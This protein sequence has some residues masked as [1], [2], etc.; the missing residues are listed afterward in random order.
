MLL[1]NIYIIRK[2]STRQNNDIDGFIQAPFLD[3]KLDKFFLEAR[4][5]RAHQKQQNHRHGADEPQGGFVHFARQKAQRSEQTERN[6]YDPSHV[7]FGQCARVANFPNC[8]RIQKRFF[9][10]AINYFRDGARISGRL[11]ENV[12]PKHFPVLDFQIIS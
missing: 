5:H 1:C 10:V 11:V 9:A 6:N 2:A 3:K 8:L 4:H 12:V 7:D